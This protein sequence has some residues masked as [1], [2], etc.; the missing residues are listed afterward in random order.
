MTDATVTTDPRPLFERALD[1]AAVLIAEVSD[2]QLSLPTPCTEFDVA[3]LLNHLTGAVRRCGDAVEETEL[4]ELLETSEVPEE[5]FLA[6]FASAQAAAR[7]AWDDDALL[8]KEVTLPWATL[9]GAV[10]VQMYALETVLHSWD[11]AVATGQERKLDDTLAEQVIPIAHEMLPAE[12]RGG[13][14][15]FEAIVPVPEDAR[16]VDRLAAYSGRTKI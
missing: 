15:P 16:A 1:Q 4:G 3:A 6:A 10:V 13:E 5:G 8:S 9:P 12:P 2:D 14:M 11:L 7:A